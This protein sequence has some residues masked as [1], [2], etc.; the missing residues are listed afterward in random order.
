VKPAI[1]CLLV[2]ACSPAI[3]PQGGS[4]RGSTSGAPDTSTSTSAPGTTS[5]ADVTT[6]LPDP[7]AS[8]DEGGSILFDVDAGVGAPLCDLWAQDC[9]VGEK[10]MPYSN[11]GGGTWNAVRCSPIDDDP[12][13]PGE[14]CTVVGSGVSGIDDCERG[15]M[16]WYLDGAT[17]MGECVAMCRGSEADS[18]CDDPCEACTINGEGTLILCL[19]SCDPIGQDC[20]AGEACY[21]IG[22]MFACAPDSSGQAGE[23]GDPCEYITV[24]DPGLFCANADAVPGCDGASGC[25]TPFCDASAPDPCAALLPGT[26]CIPLFDEGMGPEGCLGP[27]LVGG[28]LL[29]I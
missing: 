17:G 9:P 22:A 26:Q 4:T 13:A 1:A 24:C 5:V 18:V 23:A 16:C 11:D 28:C 21:P 8:S 19:A 3:D 6:G 12:K 14:A 25:C 27:G 2:A 7:T 20:A 15:A 10:C 29:P